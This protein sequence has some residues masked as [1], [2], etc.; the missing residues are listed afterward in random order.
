MKDYYK[1]LGVQREASDG[2]IRESFKKLA[3]QWHPDKNKSAGAEDKFKEIN[4]AYDNLGDASKRVNYNNLW[5]Q[6][7]EDQKAPRTSGGGDG[8]GGG[9]YTYSYVPTYTASQREESSSQN[10]GSKSKQGKKG[11]TSY[12]K[13]TR[14]SD[15]SFSYG[16]GAEETFTD[17]YDFGPFR[18]FIGAMGP[19]AQASSAYTGRH[20]AHFSS[21][22]D[23]FGRSDQFGPSFGGFDQFFK[24]DPFGADSSSP[25]FGPE[26]S[27]NEQRF[28]PTPLG[29][30]RVGRDQDT[31]LQRCKHCN[32]IM[33]LE[34]LTRHQRI[35]PNAPEHR[36]GARARFRDPDVF[37][38][39][40]QDEAPEEDG[41]AVYG[42]FAGRRNSS[43]WREEHEETLHNIRR[44]RSQAR[45]KMSDD[46]FTYRPGGE[47][48]SR[49]SAHG[50]RS[51]Q[52]AHSGASHT[53]GP[54]TVYGRTRYP[55]T[56]TSTST[57]NATT[58]T[59]RRTSAVPSRP[60]AATATASPRSRDAPPKSSVPTPAS[61][62][63]PTTESARQNGSGVAQSPSA[64]TFPSSGTGTQ[65]G[66]P[67][68]SRPS[69][70]VV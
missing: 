69:V 9:S 67:T 2:E 64:G 65:V 35:C 18:V 40:S 11:K 12:R 30:S 53:Y 51:T 55:T 36:E 27:S 43:D 62:A 56:F 68:S 49:V 59:S 7:Q 61:S 39:P 37:G 63:S 8:G 50:A 3:R 60:A 19:G 34:R 42:S 20:R 58:N 45:Q 57:S 32:Q 13:P 41:A 4:E 5:R 44:D 6:W 28:E 23:V 14:Q 33:D 21:F 46:A 70:P 31:V 24:F 38:D 48:S 54:S 16:T 52:H 1:I 15:F 66:R 10:E 17:V 29:S 22:Q 25:P 26:L 47:Q